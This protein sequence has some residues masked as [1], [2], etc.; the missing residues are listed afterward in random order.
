MNQP[1][2]MFPL[3]KQRTSRAR[4]V[5]S[6]ISTLLV[7]ITLG[8][9]VTGCSTIRP[10]PAPDHTNPQAL[11]R[12]ALAAWHDGD[13]GT[14]VILLRRAVLLSPNDAGLQADLARV[15]DT[16]PLTEADQDH[17]RSDMSAA[18]PQSRVRRSGA[19]GPA[20]APNTATPA[21]D[22]PALWPLPLQ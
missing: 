12:A 1:V 11:D 22:V 14:A 5:R 7:L 6:A 15:S 3:T 20:N 2:P 18:A 13:R 8:G 19:A 21:V 9:A 4:T 10:R 17:R 16:Y